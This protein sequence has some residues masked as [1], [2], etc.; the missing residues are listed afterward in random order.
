[1]LELGGSRSAPPLRD[2]LRQT[3]ISR[4]FVPLMIELEGRD[5][6]ASVV[7]CVPKSLAK[8]LWHPK[9]SSKFKRLVGEAANRGDRGFLWHTT[10]TRIKLTAID[11]TGPSHGIGAGSSG[12]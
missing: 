9:L 12:Q 7:T 10:C 5:H 8:H 3:A 11:L 1:M 2:L 6:P 4:D